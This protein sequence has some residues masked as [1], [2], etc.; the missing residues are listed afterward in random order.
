MNVSHEQFYRFKNSF[1]TELFHMHDTPQIL[2]MS[3][4]DH[5]IMKKKKKKQRETFSA[6]LIR[7]YIVFAIIF[8]D[9]SSVYYDTFDVQ[10]EFYI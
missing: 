6:V 7:Q 8:K 9:P 1:S 2:S 5:E 3:I 10:V 4:F